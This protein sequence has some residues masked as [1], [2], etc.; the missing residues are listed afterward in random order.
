MNKKSILESVRENGVRF[1]RMQFTDVFGTLKNVSLPVSQLEKA[2]D[3]EMM[4]DGSS[5]DGFARIEESDMYLK[6]DMDSWQVFPWDY[7]EG[8]IARLICDVYGAD[9]EPF[10]GDPRFALR[11]MLDQAKE[12][13]YTMNVGPEPEFFMFLTDDEGGPTL[14]TH[15]NAGYFEV[16]PVDHGSSA[17]R[18]IVNTLEEMGYE[19]EASHHENAPGQHEV[20]FKYGGA[21]ETADRIQTFKLVVRT[22]AR[23]HGLHATFMP[24]PIYG[25][26]GSGMHMNQSLSDVSGNN[27]FYDESKEDGLSDL[28]KW[29]MGGLLKHA[30][31]ITAI[32]NPLVNSYKRLIS[33]YEAPVY[34]AWSARNRSPLLRIPVR[35]GQSTRVEFRSPD[36]A[37]NPYLTEAVMLAAGLDGIKNKIEPPEACDFNLYA[38][39]AKERKTRGIENLPATLREAVQELLKDEVI[40]DAL[41]AHITECYTE[42]KFREYEEFCSRVTSWEVDRYLVKY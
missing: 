39:S 22:V 8:K 13:G 26:A 31:A 35:R 41:G 15:D 24:K 30:K 14:N 3:G 21:L 5:V 4:F 12:M 25:I 42:G 37:A 11:R 1:V 33:G 6:P 17:R 28:A 7:K 32:A 36:P 34:I 18:E 10:A 19:V 27:I 9:G 23:S 16:S 40:T 38:L 20:D 2:L 29:Y